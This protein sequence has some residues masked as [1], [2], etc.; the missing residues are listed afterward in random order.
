MCGKMATCNNVPVKVCAIVQILV[1]QPSLEGLSR[2]RHIGQTDIDDGETLKIRR[3]V[4]QKLKQSIRE[5][6]KRSDLD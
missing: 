5:V 6:G 4:D 2:I 3:D 1:V